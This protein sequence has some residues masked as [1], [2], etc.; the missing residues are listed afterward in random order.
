MKKEGS[1]NFNGCL[2]S[3]SWLLPYNYNAVLQL[4]VLS[5]AQHSQIEYI[6]TPVVEH[7]FIFEKW[8]EINCT[9]IINFYNFVNTIQF[10]WI[11]QSFQFS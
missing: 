11:C 3:G 4:W 9:N 5:I 1:F 2:H 6:Q 10:I 8:I 7:T